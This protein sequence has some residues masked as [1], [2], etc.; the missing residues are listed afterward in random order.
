MKKLLVIL[1][2]VVSTLIAVGIVSKHAE[3]NKAVFGSG[4]QDE[5]ALA[6]AKSLDILRDQATRRLIGNPDEFEVQKVEIDKLGMAHT[7]VRQMVNGVPVWEGEAIVHLNRDGSLA[8]ITD[9]LKE[10]IAINTSPNLAREDAIRDANQMYSGT[11]K[12]SDKPRID[13]YI[14]RGEDRDHLVYRVETPHIDGSDA[15]DVPV[16]FVDAQTGEK[17]FEYNNLQTGT[18]SSLYSGTI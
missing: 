8:T 3:A 15:S 6:K 12:I 16:I 4:S 9:D 11:A 14:F 5:L 7:R 1:A 17:V 10:G 2:V 13:M 18:G